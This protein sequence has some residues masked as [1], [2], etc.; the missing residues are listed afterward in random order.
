MVK[1]TEARILLLPFLPPSIKQ[2]T[3]GGYGSAAMLVREGHQESSNDVKSNAKDHIQDDSR[4]I[5]NTECW[6]LNG[7][8][9]NQLYGGGGG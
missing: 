3:P 7:H 4:R 8:S 9:T 1:V 2:D 5:L 6:M